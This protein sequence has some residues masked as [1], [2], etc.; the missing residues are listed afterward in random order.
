MGWSDAYESTFG[1][2][3]NKGGTPTISADVL[4]IPLYSVNLTTD[5]VNE[6]LINV[7]YSKVHEWETAH[8]CENRYGSVRRMNR[9][10][11]SDAA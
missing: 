8:I 3:K 9:E 2:Y 6:A 11:K 7:P 1:R 5:F 10:L 4:A